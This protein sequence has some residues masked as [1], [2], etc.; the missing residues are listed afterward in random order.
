MLTWSVPIMSAMQDSLQQV[1]SNELLPGI[2]AQ[3]DK[4]SKNLQNLAEKMSQIEK[5]LETMEVDIKDDFFSKNLK[6]I[7]N[8]FKKE[9]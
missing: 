4:I 2:T 3:L 6:K 7:T 9:E 5:G 1:L 8:F